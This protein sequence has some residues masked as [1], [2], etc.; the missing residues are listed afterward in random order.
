MKKNSTINPISFSWFVFIT[1]FSFAVY[2]EDLSLVEGR[3]IYNH[4]LLPNGDNVT[5]IVAGDVPVNGSQFNC[6]NCHGRSGMGAT[7]GNYVVPSITADFLFSNQYRTNKPIYNVESLYKALVEGVDSSGKPLNPLMPRYAL[8]EKNVT[9]LSIYL[10]YL[11]SKIQPGLDENY[12]HLSTVMTDDIDQSSREAVLNVM[13]KFVDEK[14]RQTRLES[15]RPNRGN[16]PEIRLPTLFRKWKLDVW[17]LKGDRS[18]WKTQLQKFYDKRPVFAMIGGLSSGSWKPIGQ[19]CEMNKLP[20]LFPST[21]LPHAEPKDWYSFHFSKGVE[22][23]ANILAKHLN[24]KNG[25][26]AIQVYCSDVASA[27][28]KILKG[29]LIKT[30]LIVDELKFNCVDNL[31]INKLQ[32]YI[33]EN[34][35]AV[36]ILWLNKEKLLKINAALKLPK[37]Y[38]SSVLLNGNLDNLSK[39]E[40][41]SVFVTYL[42]RLPDKRD[43]AM[44]RFKVWAKLRKIATTHP[45]LQAD[46]FFA[47]FAAN[48]SLEHIRRF[49][50]QDYLLEMLDHSE[51]LPLYLPRYTNAS[52]G[53][54]QRFLSKGGYILPLVNGK[55]DSKNAKW[56]QP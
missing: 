21:K 52:L 8:T 3:E 18:T 34:S 48:D 41:D 25:T 6:E 10:K 7:E 55:A 13:Q 42:N 23:E 20:C 1:G 49:R 31:P 15:K 30:K 40:S 37:L 33:L 53:P 28:A 5:A 27:A 24:L 26:H 47:V 36:V 39:L 9:S 50:I 46:A 56:I 54:G 2:A 14:N 45:K 11:S 4:G 22:L 43:S 44:T 16:K 19:F 38:L 12:I 35:D 17:E 51:G 32:S 29:K